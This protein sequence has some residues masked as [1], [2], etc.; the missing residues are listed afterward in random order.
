[1]ATAVAALFTQSQ[2]PPGLRVLQKP[3]KIVVQASGSLRIQHVD[4]GACRWIADP[5]PPLFTVAVCVSE[6]CFHETTERSL[7]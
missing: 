2:S 5:Y 3:R 7:R 1:M 6:D 4:Q